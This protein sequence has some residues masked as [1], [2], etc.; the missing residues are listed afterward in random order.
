M[1]QKGNKVYA[2]VGY[3]LRHKEKKI[4][5]LTIPGNIE[6][7]VEEKLNEPLDID[8]KSNMFFFNNNMFACHPTTMD[9]TGIKTKIITSRYT[10]DDQIA[11]MLNYGKSEEDNELFDKMQAW[12]DW[13]GEI[14][15]IIVNEKE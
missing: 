1:F 4:I 6:D 7:F 14:A 8:I 10:D 3:Y 15:R 12:R 11:L 5:G 9:Y 2:E 13:A